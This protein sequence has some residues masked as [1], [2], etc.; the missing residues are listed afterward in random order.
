MDESSKSGLLEM[1]WFIRL[2]GWVICVASIF[3]AFGNKSADPPYVIPFWVCFA[4][5]VGVSLAYFV[6]RRVSE[7]WKSKTVR[8]Y[9]S[10]YIVGATIWF[11]LI[12]LFVVLDRFLR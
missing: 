1:G 9:F 3:F 7:P 12:L 11:L 2:V 10:P 4:V 5:M 8:S 6:A